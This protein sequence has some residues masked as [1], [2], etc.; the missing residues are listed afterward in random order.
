MISA[1]S[2]NKLVASSLILNF[3]FL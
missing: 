1:I 2:F 3:Y